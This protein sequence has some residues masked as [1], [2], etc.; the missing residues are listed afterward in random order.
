MY[1]HTHTQ[2]HRH[3]HTRAHT[4]T[5]THIKKQ[6]NTSACTNTIHKITCAV[7]FAHKITTHAKAHT[8][9]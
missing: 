5:H 6:T 2:T 9:G 4:H 3:T 1:T 8:H 7:T